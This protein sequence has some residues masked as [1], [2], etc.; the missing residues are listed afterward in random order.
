MKHRF[1]IIFICFLLFSSINASADKTDKLIQL[2]IDKKIISSEEADSI[3]DELEEG[4]KEKAAKKIKKAAGESSYDKADENKDL[5]Y[6]RGMLFNTFDNNYSMR[7]NARF[8][9]VFYHENPDS[10]PSES[11]FR[12]RRARILLS[13]NLYA[14]W[15]KYNTQV[16]LEGSS[17]AARDIYMEANYFKQIVPRFGQFKVP[18]DREMLNGGFN[19]QLIER[20]IASQ[21][22]SLDRDIGLQV[23]GKVTSNSSIEYAVGIF[24]GSGI[25][26]SNVDN[27]YIYAGRLEWLPFGPFPYSE[28]AVDSPSSVK[29]A[30][31]IAG[32]YMPGLEPG[33]R[34][35]L[36]GRLGNTS[37]MPV[38]SDV[39]QWTIDLVYNYH[40][41]SL[42]G[43]YYYR[44]IDPEEITA[45][46]KQHARG[47]YLQSGFFL[48]PKH[49]EIVG[50]YSYIDPDNPVQINDNEKK[51]YAAGLNYYLDGHNAKT[52]INYSYFKT[53]SE[54][55]NE[56]EY[57]IRT[58]VTLQF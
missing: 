51:E 32:A 52:G 49:L 48:I 36:A 13:G 34:A 2:L 42:A 1:S 12:T 31:G 33:E 7:L 26:R 40:N 14:P 20:S 30:L 56:D 8:L 27:D 4:D 15:L 25:N 6:N 46:G 54:S 53:D 3:M 37:I 58:H 55:G 38:E 47:A 28:S 16:T 11:T 23:S 41:F 44:I 39:T 22:F 24:N 50:R 19:L 9:G 5:K 35:T 10:G 57:V 29:F 18:F 21:E 43:G 17:L 45:Y